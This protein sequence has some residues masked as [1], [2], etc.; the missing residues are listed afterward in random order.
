MSQLC[1]VVVVVAV[2]EQKVEEEQQE[3]GRYAAGASP[4]SHGGRWELVTGDGGS[5]SGWSR[6]RLRSGGHTD[7]EPPPQGGRPGTLSR[8]PDA[9]SC[10]RPRS[11]T[12]LTSELSAGLAS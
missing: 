10:R 2:T 4:C 12:L 5:V 11:T 7:G 3:D 6:R 8:S 1:V 9:G